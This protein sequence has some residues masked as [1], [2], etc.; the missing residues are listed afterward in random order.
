MFILVVFI[1]TVRVFFKN[2]AFQTPAAAL[3]LEAHRQ[4]FRCSLEAFSMF[5]ETGRSSKIH[6]LQAAD[7]LQAD[8]RPVVVETTCFPFCLR[9]N[10]RP[11]RP[12]MTVVSP[13]NSNSSISFE[14]LGLVESVIPPLKTVVIAQSEKPCLVQFIYVLTPNRVG[15]QELLCP[16]SPWE[17]IQRNDSLLTC[18]WQSWEQWQRL[19]RQNE[20]AFLTS[21]S[22]RRVVVWGLTTITR[23]DDIFLF[24]APPQPLPHIRPIVGRDVATLFLWQDFKPLFEASKS[25]C[26]FQVWTSN[27]LIDSILPGRSGRNGRTNQV[28]FFIIQ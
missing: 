13:F 6:F 11:I 5:D 16:W 20:S 26:L 18:S 23:I 22:L 10:L 21:V 15:R 8:D 7:L 27:D 17:L 4:P 25:R 24:K 12:A 9:S 3:P 2:G 14:S 28:L 1:L 19:E